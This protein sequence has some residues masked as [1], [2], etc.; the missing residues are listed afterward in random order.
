MIRFFKI[1]DPLRIAGVLIVL[2]LIRLPALLFDLPVLVP[3]LNWL[4][5]GEKMSEGL[6]IYR[7][8][9]ENTGALSAGVYWVLHE[10]FGRSVTVL[11]VLSLLLV[12]VQG[13]MLSQ[14]LNGLDVLREK[15][16]LPAFFYVIFASLFYDS[17][18]LSPVLMGTTFLISGSLR[19]FQLLKHG[20]SDNGVFLVGFNFGLATLFYFPYLFFIFLAI[21]ALLFYTSTVLRRYFVLIFGWFFPILLALVF[22]H[23]KGGFKSF[24]VDIL[25]YSLGLSKTSYLS[26]GAVVLIFAVPL[27]LGGIGALKSL[28]STGYVNFQQRCN[29]IMLWWFAFSI[30]VVL[31]SFE[32]SVFHLF[33]LVPGLAYFMSDL[34]IGVKRKLYQ[35]LFL[36]SL[37]IS[38]V[39]SLFSYQLNV[40]PI[41]HKQLLISEE[42]I[43][44]YGRVLVLG[45]DKRVFVNPENHPATRYLNWSL[46]QRVFTD[47]NNMLNV[48]EVYGELQADLPDAI[49]DQENLVPDLFH[50]LPEIAEHYELSEK[51]YLKKSNY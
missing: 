1:N 30:L 50:R 33:V 47:L 11:R 40:L 25:Y 36:W 17:L 39:V 32:F 5:V 37:I 48:S 9:D 20:N 18:T 43:T 51:V 13:V 44:T 14:G 16:Y 7:D 46:S 24:I 34:I 42:K 10:M 15:T 21:F 29:R 27:M 45:N 23:L 35:R 3:E 6:M 4:L 8:I 2:L 28:R 38:L 19:L 12:F 49:I 41:N 22:F 26:I 31:I